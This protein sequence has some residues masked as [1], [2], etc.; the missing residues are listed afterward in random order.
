MD[1]KGKGIKTLDK[2]HLLLE[3]GNTPGIMNITGKPQDFQFI[4]G[5]GTSGLT[6]FEYHLADKK[7]GEII[8]VEIKSRDMS[9]I[10][11]HLL[12]LPVNIPDEPDTLFLKIEI[13]KI[14]KAEPKE[15]IK[16][17][18]EIAACGDQCCGH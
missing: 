18:A 15:V 11:Q 1:Q 14:T 2:I 13:F 8:A 17:M 7:E 10:F 5:L 4:F 16:A 6:P 12:P 9:E 3:V